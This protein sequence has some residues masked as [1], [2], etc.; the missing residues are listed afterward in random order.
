MAVGFRHV[1]GERLHGQIPFCTVAVVGFHGAVAYLHGMGT[2]PNR[3]RGPDGKFATTKAQARPAD[4]GRNPADLSIPR[5]APTQELGVGGSRIYGGYL[6]SGEKDADLRGTTKYT[7]YSELLAN[8]AIVAAS[9]RLFVSMVGGA[10]WK[11]EPAKDPETDEPSDESI[12]LA[13]ETE[14]LLTRK[15]GTPWHRVVRRLS[16]YRM[17]GFAIAEWVAQRLD[18]GRIGFKKVAT[19]PQVT[20]ERWFTDPHGEVQGVAQVDPQ[21]GKEFVI[22][23]AKMIYLVDNAMSDTPEGLGLFRHIVDS[24]RRLRRYFQLE[25]YGY[26]SDMRGIPVGRAPLAELDGMVERKEM[27]KEKAQELLDGMASFL[28]DHVKNP[29]LGLMIDST[30]YRNSGEQRA[31]ASTPQW[32]VTLLDGGTYSLAEIHEAILRTQREMARVFGTEHLM[33]GENSSGSRA[34]SNDKTTT[35]G[36][37]VDSTLT[38]IAEQVDDDLVRPLFDLNGW[39]QDLRPELKTDTQVF[40]NVGELTAAIRDLA[41]AGVQV[42]RQ[43]EAVQ[44]VFDLLGLSRLAQLEEIDTDLVI[45]ASQA[46]EDAM[47]IME[48]KQMV[49]TDNGDDAPGG[50]PSSTG[51]SED[52]TPEAT[53]DDKER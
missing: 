40:R 24:G 7:T 35:F 34:L 1:R 17:Y 9:A 3:K 50:A 28:S 10:E 11:F 19:R 12:R 13:K 46:Q 14:D 43:D 4:D 45:S 52:D 26:E 23:R 31:A 8:V 29:A 32:D 49:G 30:P 15:L 44:E 37:L 20:I 16:M 25:G 21:T 5:T 42:D 51:S 22:P 39:D 2:F 27:S 38:E 47:A 18:D 53:E 6:Q 36:L 33:L 41:T 48:G